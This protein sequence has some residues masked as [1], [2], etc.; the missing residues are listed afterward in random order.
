MMLVVPLQ[1]RFG[2]SSVVMLAVVM[3]AAVLPA[4]A[5]ARVVGAVKHA[6]DNGVGAVVGGPPLWLRWGG[7]P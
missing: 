5:N 3:A 2:V 7:P 4:D 6:P 1:R